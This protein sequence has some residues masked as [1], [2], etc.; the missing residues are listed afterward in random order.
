VVVGRTVLMI[1]H[2]NT[3]NEGSLSAG[4]AEAGQQICCRDVDGSKISGTSGT[5]RERTGD[6]SFIDSVGFA[7]IF[8]RSFE[9]KRVRFKPVKKSR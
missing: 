1:V 3:A 2:A 5:V 8:E 9:R 6:D 7:D 4:K